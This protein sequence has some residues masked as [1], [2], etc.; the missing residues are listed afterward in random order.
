MQKNQ[1]EK[2]A[3]LE[4]VVHDMGFVGETVPV[5]IRGGT[6]GRDASKWDIKTALVEAGADTAE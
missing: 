4:K 3:T 5:N 2:R 1:M 6:H